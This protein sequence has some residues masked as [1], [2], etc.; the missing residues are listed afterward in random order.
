MNVIII[1]GDETIE[2]VYYLARHFEYKGYQTTIINPHSDEA[3]MLS[4]RIAGMVILGEGA[5]PSVL[6]EAGA[7]EA[8]I[9]LSLGSYDADN[10]VS[11]QIAKQSFNVPRTMALVNDPDNE[12]IFRAL[13]ITEVFS[14]TRIIGDLIEGQT[15]FDEIINQFAAAEGKVNISEVRLKKETAAVGKSLKE[16][17]L[18]HDSLIASIIRDGEVIVPRGEDHLLI[19]DRLLVITTPDDR[20]VIMR[21]LTGE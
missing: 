4:Q 3:Q 15:T 10:L 6:E 18:P 20:P 16:L 14:A 12:E 1:G 13:G 9:L 8:D 5:D 19:N 17:N 7:R 2:M 11:C 21:I